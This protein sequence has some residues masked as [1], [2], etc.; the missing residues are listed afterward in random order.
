MHSI[1]FAILTSNFTLLSRF[2]HFVQ[3]LP[4]SLNSH[5]YF[6][7]HPT[8]PHFN[9]HN[10]NPPIYNLPDYLSIPPPTSHLPYSFTVPKSIFIATSLILSNAS[11]KSN[12]RWS[13]M[14]A[15]CIDNTNLALKYDGYSTKVIMH[16]F[17]EYSIYKRFVH[18]YFALFVIYSSSYVIIISTLILS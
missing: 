5:S 9:N 2:F 12:V 10:L 7:F 4:F 8:L 3:H 1:H 14:K 6:I 13:N 16:D 11:P 17:L 18:L 15:S